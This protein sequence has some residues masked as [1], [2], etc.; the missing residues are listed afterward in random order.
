M[1]IWSNE[2]WTHAQTKLKDSSDLDRV[3][4]Q[5]EILKCVF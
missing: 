4:I 2:D 5:D 1:V 3:V